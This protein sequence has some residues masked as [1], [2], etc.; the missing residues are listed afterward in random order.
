ML[1]EKTMEVALKLL[2]KKNYTE[3]Q[4]IEKLVEIG[5]GIEE[6][7]DCFQELKR[8]NYL[9]DYNYGVTR[10][11][12]LQKKLR[13]L[14]YI[15]NDLLSKGMAIEVVRILLKEYYPIEL[16]LE[17]AKEFLKKKYHGCEIPISGWKVLA[18]AGFTE[19][20]LRH[21]FPEG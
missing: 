10:T 17:I 5:F 8:W 11:R 12:L 20:T 7:D 14:A 2:S 3:S 4:L 15:E 16:E 1:E 21:C 13:S 6:I 18:N 9:S 19:N